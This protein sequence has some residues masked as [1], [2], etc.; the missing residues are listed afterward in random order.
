MSDSVRGNAGISTF[1]IVAKRPQHTERGK[2]WFNMI[3]EIPSLPPILWSSQLETSARKLGVSVH[4][5][6]SLS[7]RM[8]AGTSV[9]VPTPSLPERTWHGTHLSSFFF[10]DRGS[11]CSQLLT[12]SFLSHTCPAILLSLLPISCGA[13]TDYRALH[14]HIQP[15]AWVLGSKTQ[16]TKLIAVNAFPIEPFSQPLKQILAL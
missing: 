13:Q 10:F 15:F 5:G 6:N 11:L 7:V 16:V 14:Y 9:S 4:T 12:P 1:Q 2:A 3:T 8:L